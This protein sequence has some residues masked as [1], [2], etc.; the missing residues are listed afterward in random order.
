MLF[1]GKTAAGLLAVIIA[2]ASAVSCGGSSGG[3]KKTSAN[4]QKTSNMTI[5]TASSETSK[6]TE[7]MTEEWTEAATEKEVFV[8]VPENTLNCEPYENNPYFDVLEQY[9][10]GNRVVLKVRAKQTVP[11]QLCAYDADGILA[12][13]YGYGCPV[14]SCYLTEGEVNYFDLDLPVDDASGLKLGYIGSAGTQTESVCA[15]SAVELLEWRKGDQ[16]IELDVRLIK[17]G[18]VD[19]NLSPLYKVL[20]Y[21]D[22]ELVAADLATLPNRFEK[23]N[24]QIDGVMQSVEV[25]TVNIFSASLDFDELEFIYQP[26]S[27]IS[28][29]SYGAGDYI[30]EYRNSFKSNGGS[31]AVSSNVKTGRVDYSNTDNSST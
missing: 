20:A 4:D 13:A 8:T 27:S 28:D 10:H 30:S 29:I 16:Y 26:C 22:G 19:F 5:S 6:A 14:S 31:G 9:I 3:S 25:E 15:L 12:E 17:S 24:L 7:S 21:K 2:L 18:G 1:N 23:R 11:Y